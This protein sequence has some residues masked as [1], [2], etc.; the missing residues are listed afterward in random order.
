MTKDK[1][2]EQRIYE[3]ARRVFLEKGLAG[4]RMQEIADEAGIN[5][6]LLHYYFRTK[7]KLFEG[8]FNE[9]IMR[10]SAGLAG[11][12]E[13]DM[14]VLGRIRSLVDIYIDVLT[15]N[16]YLP[17]FVLNEMSHNPEKFSQVFAQHVLV[18]MKK[19]ILQILDEVQKGKINPI[20]PVHLLLNVLSLII[21]PFAAVPVMSKI[22]EKTGMDIN[23]PP[24]DMEIFLKERKAIVSEFIE[25]ALVPKKN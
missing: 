5:K 22:V 3:A 9:V 18:H 7:D 14:D 21:F 19:F 1:N 4:A 2:T 20:H 15:E 12:F 24:I 6:S 25:N 11:T 10:I 13:K 23:I 16:R 17:L 8:I